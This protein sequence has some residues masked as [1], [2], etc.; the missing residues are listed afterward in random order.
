MNQMIGA[1]SAALAGFFGQRVDISAPRRFDPARICEM[2]GEGETGGYI[3]AVRSA[4]AVQGA[5]S[6][7]FIIVMPAEF[8]KG[9]AKSAPGSKKPEEP[10]PAEKLPEREEAAPPSPASFAAPSVSPAASPRKAAAKKAA[11]GPRAQPVSV[12]PLRLASFDG[13]GEAEAPEESQDNF[14]L[15]L[16]VPLEVSVEIGRTRMAVKNILE[17]R[18]GSIVELDRQ[19]G[20]PVDIIVNGQLIAKGDVVIIDDNFGVRITEILSNREIARQFK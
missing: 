4:L 20:D 9:L 13:E 6:S 5:L 16:G 10:R 7:D 1:S 18:Q 3:V 2:L 14:D 15:I 19:A 12:Q 8:A 11:D 17:I